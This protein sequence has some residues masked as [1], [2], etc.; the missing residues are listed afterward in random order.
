[1]EHVDINKIKVL[2][3]DNRTYSDSDIIQSVKTEGILVPLLVYKDGEDFV[4]IA[5]HRRLESAKHFGISSVPVTLL[6]K[7]QETIAR[8]LENIDRK[9]LHPLDEAD[10]IRKLQ[11]AGWNN[12]Q[13][14]AT[15]GIDNARIRRRAKLNNLSE[16]RLAEFRKGI[17]TAEQAEELAVFPAEIQNSIIIQ[18]WMTGEDLRKALLAKQGI[19]LDSCTNEFLDG[20]PVCSKCPENSVTDNE[21]LFPG[22]N[23]S[24][25]NPQCYAKKLV[26][27]MEKLGAKGVVNPRQE[28]KDLVP[29]APGMSWWYTFAPYNTVNPDKY[30]DETGSLL[31]KQDFH[32]ETKKDDPKTQ[33]LEKI[34]EEYTEEFEFFEKKKPAFFKECAKAYMDKNYRNIPMTGGCDLV[35]MADHII[36]RSSY[37]FNRTMDLGKSDIEGMDNV[38]RVGLTLMQMYADD[39]RTEYDSPYPQRLSISFVNND[40]EV[41]APGWM[42]LP[43]A[44]SLRKIKALKPLQD[45]LGRLK[46]I[47]DRF[48]AE[49]ESE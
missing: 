12:K 2:D 42:V 27:L 5:G 32:N 16:K 43:D 14:A 7:S 1:M 29:N 46:E 13:I 35:R 17:I 28:I 11:S 9:Q 39:F 38:T 36:D 49:K 22:L 6:D 48:K 8:A 10:Q 21:G 18:K 34:S 37:V 24:C 40:S 44:L 25:K 20:D 15:L 41:K 30:I 4:L 47:M 19:S 45:S 31:Y 26:A 3:E 23:G 33:A